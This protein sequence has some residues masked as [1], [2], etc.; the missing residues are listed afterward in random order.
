MNI[1]NTKGEKNMKKVFLI[2]SIVTI[3]G[4]L[5]AISVSAATE[6]IDGITYS[7]N[8]GNKASV[9]NANKSCTLETVIIPDTVVGS[10]GKT[11]AVTAINEGAFRDNKSI[12]YLS[13]SANITSMGGGCF[14][15][16]SNLVFVDFN[17][18][19]N[20]ISFGWGVMR[21]CNSLKAICLPDGIKTIGDQ[22][23]TGAQALTAVYLPASLE[24]IRGNKWAW[25]G[26]AFGNCP[27]LYF[28][29]EKFDVRDENGNFYNPEGF[30]SPQRP[31]V[32]YFPSNLKTI[33]APHN[34]SS[35][36]EMDENGM[37]KNNGMEDCAI[38][39]CPNIN[40][41]LVMPETYQG[42][43]DRVVVSGNAQFTDHRGD[44]ISSGLFQKCGTAEKPL[45]VVWL[46]EIDRLSLGRSGESEY[47]TYVFA[48]PAN[49]SFENTKIGTWY[50]TGSVVGGSYNGMYVVFCHANN[51]L[52]E[53][54][55]VKF[56]GSADN[57][58][59]PV[60]TGELVSDGLVHLENPRSTAVTKDATCLDNAFGIKACFCG[61]SLGE[62]EV[63]GTALG[64]DHS[65]YRGIVYVNYF[66]SSYYSHECSR[67]GNI[68]QG[69]AAFGALFVDY[70]YSVTE[71][72]INGKYAMSQF[73]GINK[74]AIAQYKEISTGFEFG[75]VV[76][77]VDDPFGAVAEGTLSES[78]IFITNGDLLVCDFA[79][80]KIN[81]I[82]EA[83]AD[84]AFTFCMFVKDGEGV[85]Y[86][87]GGETVE[88]VSVKS[89]N[90][91][92]N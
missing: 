56:V 24:I 17:D 49:T 70:G 75:F 18:N 13:L 72:P 53:K 91:I 76:A 14:N 80:V 66:D 1:Q 21:G 89:Y 25:D 29:N 28:V 74:D 30:V 46:G 5:L 50:D 6:T 63:Y 23:L 87:D 64:H 77:S 37:S 32:Y 41:V 27:N 90:D 42:Y 40:P 19:P 86:L 82:S 59:Y 78:N 4:C 58:T 62:G 38:Y 57:N 43:D 36:F 55:A 26:P 35:T 44:T 2:L 51:G 69:D 79:F 71:A 65:V 88:K 83:N 68:K 52:G 39:N 10:D 47:T 8:S 16:C 12:K 34:T 73:F 22:F 20:N 85:Y 61:K 11:Y 7:L 60:L 48:N 33:T 3:L 92:L 31:D 67:C 54:Y 15:G 9:T 45:T 84:R 81:G